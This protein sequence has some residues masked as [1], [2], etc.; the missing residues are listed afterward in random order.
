LGCQKTDLKV[1]VE[2]KSSVGEISKD[3]EE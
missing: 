1:G 2:Q 3:V